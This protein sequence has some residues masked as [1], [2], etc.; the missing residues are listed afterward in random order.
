MDDVA[1][2]GTFDATGAFM[3]KDVR[4]AFHFTTLSSRLQSVVDFIP[5]RSAGFLTFMSINIVMLCLGIYNTD[6]VSRRGDV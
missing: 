1:Y 6:G 2:F 4:L 3:S 5:H